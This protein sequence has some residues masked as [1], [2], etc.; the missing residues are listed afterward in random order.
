[1]NAAWHLPDL[2]DFRSLLNVLALCNYCILG[3]ILDYDT[4]SF[5]GLKYDEK[6][7]AEQKR[8]REL[9]DY[10]A[11]DPERRQH[12]SYVRG[13]A[14]NLRC[15]IKKH[16]DVVELNDD[17]M[18][19]DTGMDDSRPVEF[20]KDIANGYLMRQAHALLNYKIQAENEGLTSV[21]NCTAGDVRRQLKLL[22]YDNEP[23][24][25]VLNFDD[26]NLDLY[27]TWG[28]PDDK[29]RVFEKDVPLEFEG[30]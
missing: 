3:N 10:N 26:P 25:G 9:H 16:F 20:M 17:Q 4:Y 19:D 29:Y 6:V 28:F 22:F 21:V 27:T 30:T 12:M 23:I 5:P 14:I 2:T 1:M 11:L 8:L 18:D 7:M 13:L 24:Y 15:W